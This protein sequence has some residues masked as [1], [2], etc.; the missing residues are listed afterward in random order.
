MPRSGWLVSWLLIARW[1]VDGASPRDIARSIHCMWI[2][3]PITTERNE[4][5]HVNPL[6]G[7]RI[8]NPLRKWFTEGSMAGA[9]VHGNH[10]LSV[11]R[12]KP[13]ARAGNSEPYRERVDYGRHGGWREGVL[14]GRSCVGAMLRYGGRDPLKPGTLNQALEKTRNSILWFR[15]IVGCELLNFFG[16]SEEQDF[17]LYLL[18]SC[19]LVTKRRWHAIAQVPTVKIA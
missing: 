11:R 6:V 8:R 14:D 16:G 10:P 19:N 1:G 5:M 3:A 9:V 13:R 2:S 12:Q 17:S 15:E 18:R 7:A 4:H